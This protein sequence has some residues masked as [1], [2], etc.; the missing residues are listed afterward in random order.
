VGSLIKVI[1]NITL[2]L[3]KIEQLN[4]SLNSKYKNSLILVALSFIGHDIFLSTIF[5]GMIGKKPKYKIIQKIW[6]I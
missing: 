5:E 6:L 2:N 3:L 4:E 1:N